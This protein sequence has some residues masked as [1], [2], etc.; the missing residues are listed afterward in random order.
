MLFV[1]VMDVLNS[2]F[3]AAESRGLLQGLEGA[4]VRNK[5]SIFVDDVVIFVKPIE[6]DLNCVRLILD[7]FG[8]ASGFITN[9][10]KSFAIPIRCAGQVVQAGCNAVRLLFLAIIWS[11]QSL[12]SS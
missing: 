10:R 8:T 2:L 1:L 6:E 3:R 4:G 11:C 9:L 7:S 5:L 12:I